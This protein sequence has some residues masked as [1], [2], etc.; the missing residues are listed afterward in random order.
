[1]AT[2]IN[3]I[4]YSLACYLFILNYVDIYQAHMDI[5]LTIIKLIPSMVCLDNKHISPKDFGE[6]AT[7]LITSTQKY[8]DVDSKFNSLKKLKKI[9]HKTNKINADSRT[10][11]LLSMLRCGDIQSNPGPPK[12]K[13]TPKHP[14]VQCGRGVTSRSKA[15]DCDKCERWTH[16]NCTHGLITNDKYKQL[17]DDC[18][19][20]ICSECSIK[21]L[22][23]ANEDPESL[24]GDGE[25]FDAASEDT[26]TPSHATD[27]IFNCFKSKGLHFLHVNA[28]SLIPKLSELKILVNKS[29]AAVLAISETWL[30]NSVTDSEIN[31]PG[32]SVVRKDRNR[33]GGGVCIYINS[34][35]AFN[36]RSDLETSDIEAVWAEILLPKTK[37]IIIGCCYRFPKQSQFISQFEEVLTKLPNS[38]TIILGDM[39][40]CSIRKDAV[41]NKYQNMLNMCGFKQLITTPT[42]ITAKSST[43]IDHVVC[44]GMDKISQ[45]GVIPTGFSDHFVIYC[46]RKSV[47]HKVNQH[48]GAKIRS[49]KNY[50]KDTF[51]DKLSNANWTTVY[52]SKDVNKAWLF[53]CNIF[54]NILDSVAPTKEVRIKQRSEPWMSHEIL[55]NIRERDKWLNKFRK[56]KHMSEYHKHYCKLRNKVQREIKAAKREYI[57]NKVEENKNNPKQLWKHIKDLGYQSKPREASNIVLDIEGNKCHENKSIADY[58]N[59]FFTQIASKL[60]D[61]LPRPGQLFDVVSISFK[62]LYSKISPDSFQLAEV[63]E[64]FVLDELNNLDISKSTGLDGVPARF[65]KDAADVI[66]GPITYIVNLSII[67]GVVPNE[68]KLAK[69]KPLYKKKSRLDV[70]NYRPVSILSVASKILERAVFVQLNKYLVNK[71]ILYQFQSG[72]RGSYSTDTCLIYLQDHIRK[73]IASGLFTGMILLDIQ[74]A[75]DSVDH[76]IL[77]KKL[78]AMGIQSTIWFQ[79]YLSHRKQIVNVNGV[80]SDPLEITC[81]VPQGSILGPLLFLCYV[82]DMPISVKCML[83][84]YADDSALIVSDKDPEKIRKILRQNLES[85]YNWLVDNK[86]SLHMG[87]TELILFGSKRKL[88]SFPNFSI[89]CLGQ[90]IKASSSVV[91]LGLELD[92]YLAGEQTAHKIIQKVNS[93]LKF[94]YRQVNCL[95]QNTKKIICS[96]L[97]LCLFDYSISSWYGGISKLLVQKLQRTQNKVIRFILNKDSRYHINQSDFKSVGLL[98]IHSRAIQLRLNHVFN[99]FHETCPDYMQENF[100]RISNL[101]QYNTRG[102]EYNFQVPKTNTIS[103]STFYHHSIRDWS[104]LPNTIKSITQKNRFKKAVKSHLMNQIDV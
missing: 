26:H 70:G 25:G 47:R 73:Q 89:S 75:F 18:F 68:M 15:V 7:F 43:A 84:Q 74:K 83:L 94:L 96:A 17:I 27:D 95:D 86:M 36:Q 10:I 11:L 104:N 79:S 32:Y 40:M 31:I 59:K 29:K 30:D 66:K 23:F 3:G 58:F 20:Y 60:V 81:G 97:V 85:C 102:S 37:P 78:S 62:N 91:Y 12:P 16:I 24:F 88:K 38:E 8:A 44:N 19:S 21:S 76:S 65:I 63:G 101:H 80:E 90:D 33:E 98:D 56:D 99:I 45:H 1:M 28:R 39:N 4:I 57:L 72:F 93:R 13:R 103:S 54:T 22:P 49:S 46:T 2:G 14:C 71:R 51:I 6:C 35:L 34:N 41:Y 53:F 92:Q 87:K 100:N 55:E 82:N 48:N 50:N 67:S 5:D 61:M 42:R 77:C 52:N 69:V 9:V 64:D